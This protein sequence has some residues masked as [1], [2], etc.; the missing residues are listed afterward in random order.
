MPKN[1]QKTNEE[2][3]GDNSL[4]SLVAPRL[5]HLISKMD[6]QGDNCLHELVID[7]IE[8][9]LIQLVL[10]YTRGNQL[11]AAQML[12][13]N[14]NTLRKKI[15]RLQIAIAPIKASKGRA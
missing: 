11:K 10:E 1:I 14:R 2:N 6:G 8:K 3:L 9:P 13:I 5:R 12:G 4:G 7:S 15:Q